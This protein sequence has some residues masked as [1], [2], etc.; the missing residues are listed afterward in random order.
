[1]SYSEDVFFLP[2][3]TLWVLIRIALRQISN[4]YPQCIQLNYAIKTT[5][6]LPE[7]GGIGRVT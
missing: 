1:M 7:T 5:F 6:G 3:Y 2:K 4:E